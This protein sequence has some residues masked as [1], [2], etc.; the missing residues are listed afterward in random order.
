MNF[1]PYYVDPLF[2]KEENEKK[3]IR[4]TA[5]RT[6]LAFLLMSAVMVLWSYPAFSIAERFGFAKELYI[7]ATDVGLLNVFQIVISSVAFIFPFLLLSKLFNL[8]LNTAI[9]LNPIKNKKQFVALTFLGM[10]VCAFANILTIV[11]GAIL[12][13]MGFVYEANIHHENPSGIFGFLLCVL[14]TAVTPAIIEEFAMRGV[15]Y[16]G[17]KRFGDGFA[18]LVTSVIFG[19]IHGNF[20]QIPFALVLGLYLG[21]VRAKTDSIVL[22][23]LLHFLNNFFSV[24]LSFVFDK[25]S[26]DLQN[27]IY[28]FYFLAL[29]GF[30][31][32]GIM[33]LKDENAEFFKFEKVESVLSTSKKITTF[34]FAPLMIVVWAVV[35]IEAFF[36]YA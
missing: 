14:A 28:P 22:A 16:G 12:Q 9:A 26:V 11:A 19:L 10:G 31:F 29:I 15:L 6:A 33:M 25:I 35:I 27:V 4:S 17:L 7:W 30:G 18:I 8:K 34:L 36:V 21:F 2:L 32:L 1:S 3:E 13:S 24:V 23:V 20:E 5:N